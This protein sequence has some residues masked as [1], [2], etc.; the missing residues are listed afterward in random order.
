V[1]DFAP[2]SVDGWMAGFVAAE[3]SVDV[4]ELPARARAS[5]R[6]SASTESTLIG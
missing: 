3:L 4:P 6:R 5:A 2:E 1:N